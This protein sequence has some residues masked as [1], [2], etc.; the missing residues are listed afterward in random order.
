MHQNCNILFFK[1]QLLCIICAYYRKLSVHVLLVS[2]LLLENPN[3]S[4][5]NVYRL[6]RSCCIYPMLKKAAKLC[7]LLRSTK[8]MTILF[9]IYLLF[10]LFCCS[11]CVQLY[12]WK[13][14]PHCFWCAEWIKYCKL[15]FW[16]MCWFKS[17]ATQGWRT[18]VLFTVPKWYNWCGEFFLFKLALS[19]KGKVH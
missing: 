11:V 16:E 2:W 3:P 15:W 8:T 17:K 13:Q 4:F 1:H 6:L 14:S 19:W 7:S 18:F 10:L 12:I 9:F 5:N